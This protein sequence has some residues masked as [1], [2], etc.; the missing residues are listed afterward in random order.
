[1]PA[2]RDFAVSVVNRVPGP[3]ATLFRS[4]GLLAK[5]SA[6]ILERLLPTD[7]REVVVR[8][9][10]ARGLRLL[11][12][13]Q[14]EKYYWTGTYER[15]V[16]DAFKA[17]LLPGDVV[18]DIG[19]HIGFFTLLA[20]RLVGPDGEVHAF[21][22]NPAAH[23]RLSANARLN[24]FENVRFHHLALSGSNDTAVLHIHQ[25]ASMSSLH[26]VAETRA[27]LSVLCR[28]VD[29]LVQ[30]T[31]SVPDVMKIDVEH[32]E[33]DVLRGGGQLIKRGVTVIFEGSSP[34]TVDEAERLLPS[35]EFE[36]MTP[37][38][39]VFRPVRRRAE[40]AAR[41]G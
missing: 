11:I 30:A 6:P 15:E 5:T 2:A 26:P 14:Q 34:E 3:L 25:E 23:A 33:L 4:G 19:A 31:S 17:L 37:R 28:T 1:M 16:Q 13:P 29:E 32:A 9:G 41:V 39:A 38:H 35:Y 36:R 20:A 12:D 27:T 22:P 7:T 18:W 24:K 10:R 40:I 8:S 21:E